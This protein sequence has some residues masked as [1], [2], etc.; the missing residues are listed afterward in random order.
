MR[1]SVCAIFYTAGQGY[2]DMDGSYND[3]TNFEGITTDPDKWL[4]EHNH[5]RWLEVA[6][7]DEEDEDHINK[8]CCCIESEGEFSFNWDEIEIK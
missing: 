4:E 5:N 1:V 8:E 7:G 3:G 6:C 2:W